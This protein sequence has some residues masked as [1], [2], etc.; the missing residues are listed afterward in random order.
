MIETFKILNAYCKIDKSALFQQPNQP[1]IM[2]GNYEV[3]NSTLI[4]VNTF[5]PT[6]L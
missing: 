1:E 6:V 5:L 3:K 2:D 4:P